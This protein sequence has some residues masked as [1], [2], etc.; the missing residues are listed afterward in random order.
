MGLR[1]TA[2][3]CR[4]AQFQSTHPVWDGTTD[5]VEVAQDDPQFQSTHPVWDGTSCV[6]G[7]FQKGRY[8]NPPIPCGMGRSL[9]NTAH[10]NNRF[11]STHPVWDGTTI[12]VNVT[13]QPAISI[14]PSRVGW[15][16]GVGAVK[17]LPL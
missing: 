2:G 8:F 17:V 11:Q 16:S 7:H 12:T 4:Q 9:A 3:R 15:D 5:N 1:E 13:T 14:H 10:S 6:Y